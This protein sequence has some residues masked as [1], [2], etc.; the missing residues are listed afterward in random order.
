MEN[1]IVAMAV[2]EQKGKY[3]QRRISTTTAVLP[4]S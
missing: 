3:E 2:M 1:L 4:T